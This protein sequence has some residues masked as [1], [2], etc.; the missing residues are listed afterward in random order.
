M[1]GWMDQGDW[2]FL[3]PMSKLGV[4]GFNNMADKNGDIL[5]MYVKDAYEAID[6]EQ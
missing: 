4:L 3:I 1:A 5:W 6:H 2:F